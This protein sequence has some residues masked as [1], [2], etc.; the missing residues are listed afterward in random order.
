MQK[1]SKFRLKKKFGSFGFEFF[2]GLHHNRG[3]FRFF[4]P[5]DLASTIR[6]SF[7][8]LFKKKLGENLHL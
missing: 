2:G 5:L 1:S 8:N 4:G 6:G 3:M 7:V